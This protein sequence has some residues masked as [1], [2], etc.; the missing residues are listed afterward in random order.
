MKEQIA[1][2]QAEIKNQEFE[3]KPHLKVLND[4]QSIFITGDQKLIKKASIE[5]ISNYL[6]K[7]KDKYEY[8]EKVKL[9]SI[10]SYMKNIKKYLNKK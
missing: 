2:L 9:N 6:S 5:K 8:E 4:L 7:N 10:I 3:T 1:K